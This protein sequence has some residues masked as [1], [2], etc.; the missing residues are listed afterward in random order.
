MNT[1]LRWGLARE[2]RGLNII[3]LSFGF[4]KGGLKTRPC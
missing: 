1:L 3:Y 2:A 4:N